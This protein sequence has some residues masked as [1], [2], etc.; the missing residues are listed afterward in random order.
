MDTISE[1]PSQ[2]LGK[3]FDCF[4]YL[5]E[6]SFSGYDVKE[7][8]KSYK[9]LGGLQGEHRWGGGGGSSHGLTL[10]KQTHCT[11]FRTVPGTVSQ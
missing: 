5:E 1:F 9:F 6:L 10:R 7:V 2:Y 11:E 3:L 8:L 4:R